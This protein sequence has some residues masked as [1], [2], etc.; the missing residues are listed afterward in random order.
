MKDNHRLCQGY[1]RNDTQRR[2]TREVKRNLLKIRERS[3][4]TTYNENEMHPQH[5]QIINASIQYDLQK[6]MS[7]HELLRQSQTGIR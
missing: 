4:A 3:A 6:N 2:N 5:E 1:H 7:E